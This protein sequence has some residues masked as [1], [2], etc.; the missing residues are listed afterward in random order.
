MA[1]DRNTIGLTDESFA[2]TISRPAAVMTLKRMS[3]GPDENRREVSRS[4]LQFA[5]FAG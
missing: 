4:R 2:V 1:R 3:T 5:A